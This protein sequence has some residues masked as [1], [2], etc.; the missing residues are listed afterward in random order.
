MIKWFFGVMDNTP[1]YG[2]GNEGSSPSG[3]TKCICSSIGRVT[4]LHTEGRWFKSDGNYKFGKTTV[5]GF[6]CFTF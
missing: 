2:R 4:V 6:F 5:K 3:T 1:R